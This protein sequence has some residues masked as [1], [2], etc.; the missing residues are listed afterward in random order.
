M[1]NLWLCTAMTSIEA[2]MIVHEMNKIVNQSTTHTCIL[3]C[4]ECA[5][6][7]NYIMNKFL[8]FNCVVDAYSIFDCKCSKQFWIIFMFWIF[9]LTLLSKV[10]WSRFVYWLTSAYRIIYYLTLYLTNSIFALLHFDAHN[11]TSLLF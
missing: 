10:Q 9:E 11:L 8:F 4:C 6:L 7:L 2:F 5:M 3:R 1:K